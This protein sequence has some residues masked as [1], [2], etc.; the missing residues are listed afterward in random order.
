[1]ENNLQNDINQ[2]EVTMEFAKELIK[3]AD[4]A[5]RLTNNPDFKAIILDGYFA[6]EAA[7][8]GH[9]VGDPET[10]M[11]P[12]R[13]TMVQNDLIGIGALKRYMSTILMLGRRAEADLLEQGETLEELRAA[14]NDPDFDG[15][16]D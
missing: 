15:G 6:D 5:Q 12:K 4:V 10:V 9:L 7:R 11:D 3:N 2:V 14:E 1:M 16:D 13:G 8:L